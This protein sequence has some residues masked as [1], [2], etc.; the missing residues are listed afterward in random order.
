MVKFIQKSRN[1][2]WNFSRQPINENLLSLQI[3]FLELYNKT[4]RSLC[5]RTVGISI[6]K[7][8]MGETTNQSFGKTS[9]LKLHGISANESTG[10][11]YSFLR[12]FISSLEVAAKRIGER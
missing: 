3:F 10:Q 1:T 8:V 9:L 2:H 5:N 11:N 7:K 6:S 12:K 4:L